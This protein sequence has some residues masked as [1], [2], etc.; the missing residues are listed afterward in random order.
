MAKFFGQGGEGQGGSRGWFRRGDSEWKKSMQQNDLERQVA[1]QTGSYKGGKKTS[2]SYV[3]GRKIAAA[4]RAKSAKKM[5]ELNRV[6]GHKTR[7]SGR[8]GF[9]EG[10]GTPRQSGDIFGARGGNPD[11]P[12]GGWGWEQSSGGKGGGFGWDQ[13]SNRGGGGGKNIWE[14]GKKD[15]GGKNKNIWE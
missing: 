1:R 8:S 3:A 10:G 15:N 7:H 12:S 5:E 13:T 9:T 14:Q 6:S 11:R 2:E 4:D